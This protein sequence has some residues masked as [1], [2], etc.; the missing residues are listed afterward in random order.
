MYFL[1]GNPVFIIVGNTL[2]KM[3]VFVGRPLMKPASLSG[4][5][6]QAVVLVDVEPGS[7]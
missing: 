4:G 7:S 3:W 2:T 1:W 6:L 5:A